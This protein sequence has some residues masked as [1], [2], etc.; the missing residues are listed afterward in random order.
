MQCSYF[1]CLF[2]NADVNSLTNSREYTYAMSITIFFHSI[3]GITELDAIPY[4]SIHG[5]LN[6][7]PP[8]DYRSVV[9]ALQGFS[10]V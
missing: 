6:F 2:G 1:L 4:F 9:F 10:A 5:Y 7:R 8:Y 3:F